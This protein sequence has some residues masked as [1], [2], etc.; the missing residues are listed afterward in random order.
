MKKYEQKEEYY[1]DKLTIEQLANYREDGW[2]EYI[3]ES[4]QPWQIDSVGKPEGGYI[5]KYTFLK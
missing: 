3:V 2:N 1:Q 4:L 5:Y